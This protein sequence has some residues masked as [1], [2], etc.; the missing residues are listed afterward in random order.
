MPK[1]T[2]TWLSGRGRPLSWGA[3]LTWGIPLP[4]AVDGSCL[5][6][7]RRSI[8]Q[9]E[10]R[11]RLHATRGDRRVTVQQLRQRL[12]LVGATDQ[13]E[14]VISAGEGRVGEGHPARL[15]VGAAQGDESVRD[16]EDGVV[17]NERRAVAVGSETE[18]DEVETRREFGGVLTTRFVEVRLF[19]AHGLDWR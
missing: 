16:V 3:V 10:R 5:W 7:D 14:K 4:S 6:G 18:V 2:M 13:P 19:D 1:T 9:D 15:L 8:G 11:A 17:R 12:A